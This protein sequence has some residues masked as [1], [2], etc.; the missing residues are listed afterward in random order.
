MNIAKIIG[1]NIKY[2]IDKE[3][4]SLRK[5]GRIIGVTHPTLKNYIEGNQVID[6]EKLMKIAHYFN[7]SFDYFFKQDNA[8][9]KFLFR[10]DK[11]KDNIDELDVVFLKESI[12]NYL[13]IVG[14][15]QY[16]FLP[17]KY[18]LDFTQ[19][20]KEIFKAVEKIAIEQRKLAGIEDVI[21]N[22]YYEVIQN[23]GVNVIVKD[24]KNDNYFGAS[25]FVNNKESYIL[26]NDS[27]NISEERK[28]FSLIHEYAHL[29]FD[30]DQ[31]T[32][33]LSSELYESARGD[34]RER[35]A[36]KFA[37]YFLMPRKMVKKYFEK[38][39]N[40]EYLKM[41]QYFKVSLQS[42][43][44]LLAEYKYISKK[45]HSN[46]WKKVNERNLKKEEPFPIE[47]IA[48]ENKNLKLMSELK[49]RYRKDEI[50][51]NKISEVLGLKTIETRLML[52]KW[53]REYEQYLQSG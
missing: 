41:K 27:E 4:I 49:N 34:V 44:Y 45:E 9:L 14:R 28:I 21:P 10:A 6:S 37:G 17:Q 48:L 1:E 13:S 53:N 5:M 51:A 15:A 2:L 26:V 39:G 42:L 35:I 18:S 32:D 11:P 38:Y 40:K 7:E 33:K 52:R 22:N 25:S 30:S 46:F 31:Y 3:K 12:N 29:L 43:Y 24:F 16:D 19:S 8:D 36:N 20:N 47:K 50:S 23:T